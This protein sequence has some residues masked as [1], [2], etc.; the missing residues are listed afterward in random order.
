MKSRKARALVARGVVVL[1]ASLGA[2]AVSA[3]QAWACACGCD[4]FDGGGS[5]MFPLGAGGRIYLEW[6]YQN[7]HQNWHG[8]SS[9]PGFEN[10][11]KQIETHFVTLGGQYMFNADWGVRLELPYAVRH[12]VTVNDDGDRQ[13]IHWNDLG[14]ARVRGVYD[15]FF[16]DHTLGVSFG[17]KLPT[18]NYTKEGVD[19]DT[20]L[21]SGS[22]DIL[23]GA[24][25]RRVLWRGWSFFTQALLDVPVL[26]RN[27]YY[28]GT[29]FVASLGTIY[30]FDVTED[31]TVAPL[32]QVIAGVRTR[33]TGMASAN[34]VAS[35]YERLLV[36]PGFSVSMGPFMIYADAEVPVFVDVRGD[37]VVAPVL[38]KVMASVSF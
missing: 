11:D 27:Q 21:G 30:T 1:V 25:Y 16:D 28:P 13:S 12:F 6:D 36:S 23:L 8:T 32:L 14:D 3:Q 18:G 37:Q 15:G 34:P 24:F 4:T 9:A 33:D 17:L 35:G 10:S 31:L 38:F 26:D 29:E 22:L 2:M 20:Q 19:R 7:Q 5:N